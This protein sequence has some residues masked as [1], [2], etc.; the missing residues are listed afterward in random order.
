MTLTRGSAV[1]ALLISLLAIVI[2]GCAAATE[3]GDESEP[4]ALV[5]FASTSDIGLGTARI[6]LNIRMIDGTSFDDQAARLEVTYTAPN[7]DEPLVVDDLTWRVWPVRSGVYTAT[8]NFD[9]VGLWSIKVRVRNDDSIL[10]A[11]SGVLV[12][13]ATDAPN[14]GDPVPLTATKIRPED[15]NLRSIT[16]APVPDPDLYSISFDDA[17]ATGMP[18]VISFSTPAYCQTGTCGPQTDVLSELDEKYKGRANFIHVEI[19]D[20]PEEMLDAG[21]PSIGIETPIIFEWEFYTEPWTFVVD[22]DGIVA[23][24]FESFVTLEEIE[25]YL[26]PILDDA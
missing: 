6:P 25:G 20:N 11:V 5:V 15:G 10:P 26:L 4:D 9:D 13:S 12:K 14:I 24:R 8:M 17:V 18:T 22:G 16:S 2:L 23:G 21:D 19:F 7:S 3:L 1:S